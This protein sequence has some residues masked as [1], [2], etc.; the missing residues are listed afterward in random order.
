MGLRGYG[1]D[2]GWGWGSGI[3]MSARTYVQLS[4]LFIFSSL[5]FL[6]WHF[7]TCVAI[8]FLLRR[9]A[10]WRRRVICAPAVDS[11]RPLAAGRWHTPAQAVYSL[12][13]RVCAWACAGGVGGSQRSMIECYLMWNSKFLWPACVIYVNVTIF[14]AYFTAVG[15][16][17]REVKVPKTWKLMKFSGIRVEFNCATFQIYS[18]SYFAIS[19]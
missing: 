14:A 8:N 1:W 11:V 13:S 4:K 15:E 5:F 19:T 16:F 10:N 18:Q 12:P 2:W 7:F 17:P 6:C 3:C 9:V